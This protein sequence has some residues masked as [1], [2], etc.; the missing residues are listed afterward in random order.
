MLLDTQDA[1]MARFSFKPR[2]PLEVKIVIMQNP[3][4][5]FVQSPK[6][7]LWSPHAFFHPQESSFDS[8]THS[9]TQTLSPTSHAHSPTP[10]TIPTRQQLVPFPISSVP[11]L[12]REHRKRKNEERNRREGRTLL[13]LAKIARSTAKGWP[14]EDQSQNPPRCT[15]GRVC[16]HRKRRKKS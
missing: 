9:Y 6:N 2:Q 13:S 3:K 1:N 10:Q 14:W 15:W 7:N 8:L 5:Y 11:T 4:I 16:K 12:K